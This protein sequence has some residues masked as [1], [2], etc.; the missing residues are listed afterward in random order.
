[1]IGAASDAGIVVSLGHTNASQPVVARA[2]KAGAT[3]STHFFNGCARLIDR[4]ENPIFSQLAESSLHA[5]LIANGHHVPFPALPVAFRAKGFAK[6]ILVSDISSLSGL[7]EG[8]YKMEE[9]RV[10]LRDGGLFVKGDWRLSGA[11]RTLDRDV[12]LLARHPEVGIEKAL[13]MATA[14]PA[15]ALHDAAGAEFTPGGNGPLG[16]FSWDGSNLL[17]EKR[18]GF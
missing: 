5:C 16:V 17:L 6:C 14:N 7:P 11:A 9:N 10:E 18:I 1:M 2:T 12:E 4:H 15:A 8:E 13:L 3:I